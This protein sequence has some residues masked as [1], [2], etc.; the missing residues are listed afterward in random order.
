M[1]VP[2]V[3]QSATQ[4][5][6]LAQLDVNFN[7]PITVGSTDV[8]LGDTIDTL[9]GMVEIT[10]VE[11][12]G[13]LTGN[14]TG[15]L[16]G[17]ADTV[18][19][20]A[21]L[22]AANVFTG[23]NNFSLNLN[24]AQG[25][26]LIGY[27]PTVLFFGKTVDGTSPIL[28]GDIA[29]SITFTGLTSGGP[30]TAARIFATVDGTVAV[31]TVPASLSF[32]TTDAGGILNTH[33]IIYPNGT[34]NFIGGVSTPSVAV[35]QA[36]SVITVDCSLSNVFETT[37]TASVTTVTFINAFD[38]QTINWFITQDATGGRT[39]GWDGT[40]KFPGGAV[41]GVLSTAADAVD[42]VVLSYRD[43]TG[44]WYGSVL[45]DFSSNAPIPPPAESYFVTYD[46]A[47]NNTV[48]VEFVG[49]TAA[50]IDWNDGTIEA[51]TS[52]GV[53]SHTYVA[54]SGTVSVAIY[55]TC[56]E[57]ILVDGFTAITSW[58]VGLTP[59][60][61][62]SSADLVSVPDFL[63]ADITWLRL[64]DC[65]T[66]DDGNVTTWNTS[67]ITDMSEMFEAC[68]IF[69]Q[70][71]SG[72]DTS[73]VEYMTNMFN[74]A[75]AFDQPIG[76]WDTSFVVN[77]QSM[78][79]GATA[80]NQDISLWSTGAVLDMSDMFNGAVVFNQPIGTWNVSSVQTMARMFQ[81]ATAFNGNISAW[82]TI[83]VTT[84]EGMFSGA[85]AFNQP[86]GTWNT[87]TVSDMHEM[88]MGAT[89]FNGNIAAWNTASVGTMQ[90]M[91]QGAT[92]FNQ[93][94]S[95]WDT[96]FVGTMQGMFA[97]ATTFN[98]PIGSWVTTALTNMA[99]T[100]FGAAA[101][102]GNIGAWATGAVTS[103]NGTFNGASAF[104]Q[105]ISLWDTS[106]VQNMASMFR[107]TSAFNQDISPWD[108][109][110]VTTMD[111]MFENATVFDQD[112]STWVV[113]LIPTL[114]TDFNTGGVLTPAFYP[115]WGV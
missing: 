89:A 78:F 112:I 64:T 40:I 99:G 10:S 111:N 14:V 32:A 13:H 35:T 51:F 94:I 5:L 26:D 16:T 39:M 34:T 31:G 103:M 29:G 43:T 44:F 98:Q 7:T 72:W 67:N 81:G 25:V 52:S 50:S 102:N 53:K 19:D 115:V 114:P 57:L 23:I 100:F 71:I 77:M 54:V 48:N 108:T 21:Y 12:V 93:N 107:N 61:Y 37:L 41:S 9:V 90:S 82:S 55:G 113:T 105:D 66:F 47:L 109:A 96:S 2:Y 33:Q 101:F 20:G 92:A 17:N 110:L 74:G 76:I 80:F 8:Q 70:D 22:S 65:S 63:P 79:I 56:D 68:T 3:F 42:L 45:Q 58:D 95:T 106:A 18:T 104:N 97:N 83:V 59:I 73:A 15:D 24:L 75:A 28:D 46:L 27:E 4:P 69:N 60:V 84:M 38:G 11:F 87:G 36:A 86:I 6:P 1:A 91:F 62:L 85:T 49:T 88:F 30:G